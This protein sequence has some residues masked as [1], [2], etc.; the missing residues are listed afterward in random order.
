MY[1]VDVLQWWTICCSIISIS[2]HLFCII[3]I[4]LIIKKIISVAV[5]GVSWKENV[6]S[7]RKC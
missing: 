1:N 6:I 2:Y 4:I 7:S 5:A 3:N